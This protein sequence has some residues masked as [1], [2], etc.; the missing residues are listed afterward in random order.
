M[1]RH[2]FRRLV[3]PILLLAWTSSAAFVAA[4]DT[5]DEFGGVQETPEHFDQHEYAISTRVTIDFED[6]AVREFVDLLKEQAP[7]LNI[8][9]RPDVDG[10]VLPQLLLR[11]ISA[12]TALRSLEQLSLNSLGVE[13]DDSMEY[14]VIGPNDNDPNRLFQS[15][16]VLNVSGFLMDSAQTILPE[17]QEQLMSAI[18]AGREMLA[19]NSGSM[20]ISLHPATGLLFVKG[21]PEETILVKRIVSE[22]VPTPDLLPPMGGGAAGSAGGGMPSDRIPSTEK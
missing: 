7:A 9:I 20:K 4:Q 8:M 11:N 12:D 2:S 21:S 14:Y 6:I 19:T 17:K 22:L 3:F 1:T 15:V 5:S 10:I 18:E 13:M 16:E